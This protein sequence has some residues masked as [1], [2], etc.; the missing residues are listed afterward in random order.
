TVSQLRRCSGIRNAGPCILSAAL[1][2]AGSSAFFRH[3]DPPHE[4]L[5]RQNQT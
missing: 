5:P 1:G 4:K 3:S 2:C